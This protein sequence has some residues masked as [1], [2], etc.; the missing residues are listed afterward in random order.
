MKSASSR[1]PIEIGRRFNDRGIGEFGGKRRG[2]V[3]REEPVGAEKVEGSHQAECFTSSILI[4]AIA[5]TGLL[6]SIMDGSPA[7]LV[8]LVNNCRELVDQSIQMI[9]R[10]LTWAGALTIIYLSIVPAVDRPVTGAGQWAEHFSAFASVAVCFAIGCRLSPIRL[11]TLAI[12]FCGGVESLQ[13]PLPTRHARVS[14][15][16][17]D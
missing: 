4:F 17:I 15:L 1:A 5:L 3:E 16:V 8:A 9:A 11:V 10:A 6:E 13:V 7:N 2:E 14:D 12:L